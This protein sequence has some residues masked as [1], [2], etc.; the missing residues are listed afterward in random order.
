MARYADKLLAEGEVIA[1]RTRQ[2]WLAPVVQAAY[3]LILI[4]VSLVVWVLSLNLGAGGALGSLRSIVGYGAAA[5][6]IIGVLGVGLVFWRWSAQDYIITNHRVLKVEGI[7][8]KHSADSSLEK[9]N[10]AV[11]DQSIWGRMFGFGDLDIM[12][13]SEETVDRYKW[14]N[15]AP[16]FKKEMLNQKNNLEMDMRHMPSPPLRAAPAE[17]A[18]TPAAT[19]AMSADQVTATLDR[20]ADLRDRG[21]VTPEEYEAKK[22]EL[23]GRL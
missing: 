18:P 13:A 1:L 9:I 19:P 16:T 21:A 7:F 4:V 6:I 20:L 2:H 17:P 23:L 3:P 8:N 11:L 14:L 5:G 10:D 15:R 12:T 22:A